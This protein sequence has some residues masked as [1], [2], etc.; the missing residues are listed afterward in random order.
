MKKLLL[1][2]GVLI[3]L[4]GLTSQS[5]A[6]RASD[7]TNKTVYAQALV[8]SALNGNTPFVTGSVNTT[9]L[10]YCGQPFTGPTSG[11]NEG[12]LMACGSTPIISLALSGGSSGGTVKSTTPTPQIQILILRQ[13]HRRKRLYLRQPWRRIQ[14]CMLT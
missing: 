9:T 2:L 13:K 8:S 12:T 10:Q 7:S 6:L 5:Y 14:H 4:V 11:S 1:V 3:G